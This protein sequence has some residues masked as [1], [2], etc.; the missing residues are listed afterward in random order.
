MFRSY[1]Q[2]TFRNLWKNR[3]FTIIN[4]IGLGIALAVCIVAF[5]NHV[6]N[7]EFDRTHENFNEIY[8]I[9]CFRD[10]Q[11]SEM[12]YGAVPAT[13]GLHIK[14]DV[15]GVERSARAMRSRSPVKIGDNIFQAQ[16]SYID[17]EF[18]DIFTFPLKYGDKSTLRNQGNL[19]LSEKMSKTLFGDEFPVGKSIS[20]INDQSREFTF[21]VGGVFTDLPDNSS[22]RIDILTHFDNFLLM[23][24]VNDAD[25]K[26]NT[27]LLFVQIPDRSI[28]PSV[29]SGLKNYLPVQNR[30]RED[31]R[32]SRFSLVPLKDVGSNPRS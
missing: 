6:F 21:I 16:V 26:F 22:F 32:I 7:Y 10:L 3:V 30:A 17:P 12:E 14:N 5:F 23:W 15:P 18:L 1:L 20:V 29:A 13:L 19:L 4:I 2:V 8:R 27:S 31:F 11:G 25:W 28:L 9:T 24:N